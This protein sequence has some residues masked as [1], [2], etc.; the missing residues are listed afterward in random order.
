MSGTRGPLLL[1]PLT[2]LF[3]C[4]LTTVADAPTGTATVADALTGTC[5]LSRSSSSAPVVA[6][7][8]D[9]AGV[10]GARAVTDMSAKQQDVVHF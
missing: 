4:C 3:T 9:K 6:V 8:G 7:V 5:M 2:R 10:R 1:L